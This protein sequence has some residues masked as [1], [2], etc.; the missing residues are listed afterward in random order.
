M[1][2]DGRRRITPEQIKE[3][4]KLWDNGH[5]ETFQQ[6][7]ERYGIHHTTV[8]R[9]VRPLVLALGSQAPAR[10]R[11]PHATPL[12]VEKQVLR[13]YESGLSYVEIT[14]EFGTVERTI[15]RILVRHGITPE[16]REGR[17]QLKTA[18][19]KARAKRR[20]EPDPTM[21]VGR[22]LAAMMAREISRRDL[23][24]WWDQALGMRKRVCQDCG[25]AE[26]LLHAWEHKSSSVMT[27]FD[28][29]DRVLIGLGL[30]WWEVFDPQEHAPLTLK[31]RQR[32]DVL[33]W[34]DVVDRASRLWEGEV[35]LG[36]DDPV[37]DAERV[38][39]LEWAA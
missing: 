1:T 14:R 23:W 26:R 2:T 13:A 24:S 37:L 31:P 16:R 25:I 21:V 4:R 35:L 39:A 12:A 32:D 33:A 27:C 29:A 7:A 19:A 15:K 34:L 17:P 36:P 38:A 28:T 3:M 22:P 6:I 5:G 10:R 11:L 8:M 18:P 30:L 20:Y 9:R